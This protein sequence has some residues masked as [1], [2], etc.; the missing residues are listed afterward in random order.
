[1]KKK[2]I[3]IITVLFAVNYASSQITKGNWMVGGNGSFSSQ[4]ETL[5]LIDAKG[6]GIHLSPAA[7]YFFIDKLAG[8]LRAKYDYNKVEYYG[9][10]SNTS[11]FGFGPFIRYY[12]LDP[13]KIINFF[14]ESAY[15]FSRNSGSNSTSTNSNAFTFSAGPIIYLN[16]SVGIEF[17][18]S[19][20][21]NNN[22]AIKANTKTFFLSI[23]F[24]I[25]LEKEK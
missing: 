6:I 3:L 5:N 11:Q 8:G 23:G 13:E 15:Q 18:G 25:H 20:E 7:G 24:Q 14:T 21:L 16:S 10:T 22:K 9:N 2:I 1:M 17:A 4:K 12:F 19:Y